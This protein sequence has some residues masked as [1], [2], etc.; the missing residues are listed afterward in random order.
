M[1]REWVN[2]FLHTQIIKDST[3]SIRSAIVHNTITK[4]CFKFLPEKLF[5]TNITPMT[6][7]P[8]LT[9]NG[10]ITTKK[11]GGRWVAGFV[12]ADTPT[13]FAEFQPIPEEVHANLETTE[14]QENVIV[15][16]RQGKKK[17]VQIE[18]QIPFENTIEHL[19]DLGNV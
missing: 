19:I 10:F 6:I 1:V 15:P 2:I 3:A 14:Q 18:V 16:K 17:K 9:Q 4:W 8:V 12:F 7:G 11:P 13:E 5:T